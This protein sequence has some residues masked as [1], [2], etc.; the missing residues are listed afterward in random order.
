MSP[1]K[2]VS[3]FSYKAL[4]AEGNKVSGI[5]SAETSGAAHLALLERGFQPL[6]V[7]E[8]RSVMSFE[9][10]KKM[11]PRKDVG[12]FSRQLAVFMR[13]GIPIMEA[14]EVILDE[15]AQKM[16][17][18]VILAMI[19]DLRAGD[20]FAGAAA[21]HPEAFPPTTWASSSPRR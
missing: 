3:K 2:T 17:R 7:T 19:E 9:I 12:H 1:Q 15:T 13:A 20:T 8:K 16:M 21:A 4:D 14:M 6:E 18:K 10:T 11:V 5:E